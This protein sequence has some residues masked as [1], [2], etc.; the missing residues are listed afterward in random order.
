MADD[1]FVT[2]ALDPVG[3]VRTDGASGRET[4][5]RAEATIQLDTDQFDAD[6]LR[7]LGNFSH[8][9]IFLCTD[10]PRGNGVSS[11]QRSRRIGDPADNRD[12]HDVPE[13]VALVQCELLDAT[14]LDVTVRGLDV[15]D[16]TPILDF[17]PY[18]AEFGPDGDLSQPFWAS[19]LT[20]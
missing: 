9:S 14:G 13:Q 10:E 16:G 20:R 2:V 6:T 15:P 19:E 7:G 3:V 18:M 4:D 12:V 1:G 5:E 11:E 17:K 8:V